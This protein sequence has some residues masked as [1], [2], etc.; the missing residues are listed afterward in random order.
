MWAD[1]PAP[2]GTAGPDLEGRGVDEPGVHRAEGRS[3]ESREDCRMAGDAFRDALAAAQPGEDELVGVCA[4]GFRAGRA[5][6]RPPVAACLCKSPRRRRRR[7]RVRR[8]PGRP[9]RSQAAAGRGWCSRR[10]RRRGRPSPGS[11]DRRPERGGPGVSGGGCQPSPVL[12]ADRD[13]AAPVPG[14][15]HQRS[16]T[17]G[18]LTHPLAGPQRQ[19]QVVPTVLVEDPAAE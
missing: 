8:W 18:P 6:G 1:G 15:G 11:Q 17:A 7:G 13:P 5:D 9:G 3:G 16:V 10:P 2:V 19:R 12:G 14:G 4:V